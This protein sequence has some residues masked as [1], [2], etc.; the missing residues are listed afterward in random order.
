[1]TRRD[2]RRCDATRKPVNPETFALCFCPS[3]DMKAF[4]SEHYRNYVCTHFTF[5]PW[6]IDRT[7]MARRAAPFLSARSSGWP[8]RRLL[9]SPVWRVKWHEHALVPQLVRSD[10][11]NPFTVG[12]IFSILRE[13]TTISTRAYR[14]SQI[15]NF[16]IFLI[17][18]YFIFDLILIFL[19]SF[20]T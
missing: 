17:C 3:S 2:V 9:R 16:F 11:F 18:W 13:T 20:L 12:I 4:L 10:S 6:P 15:E 19:S 7:A 5:V 8:S 14:S 1:V